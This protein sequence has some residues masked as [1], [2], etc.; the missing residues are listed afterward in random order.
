M[1]NNL[2]QKIPLHFVTGL[3]IRQC[4]LMVKSNS[5]LLLLSLKSSYA[6]WCCMQHI[7]FSFSG[8]FIK[9]MHCFFPSASLIEDIYSA[10]I[11]NIFPLHWQVIWAHFLARYLI[12]HEKLQNRALLFAVVCMSTVNRVMSFLIWIIWLNKLGTSQVVQG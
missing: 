10:I 5:F 4:F 6:F 2:C 7:W 1:T 11:C 3:I 12:V 8:T 9:E